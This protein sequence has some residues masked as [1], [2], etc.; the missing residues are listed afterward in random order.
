MVIYATNLTE[1]DVR[2]VF[3]LLSAIFLGTTSAAEVFMAAA[4]IW[5]VRQTR[6]R[7]NLRRGAMLRNS[8]Q[9][10]VS[11]DLF[12]YLSNGPA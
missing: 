6:R 12:L 4:I 1:K 9:V 7:D 10:F 11:L 2:E 5:K 3:W 8:K